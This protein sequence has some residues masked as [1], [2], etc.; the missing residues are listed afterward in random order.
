MEEKLR[1]YLKILL[2]KR[3]SD[4][5]LGTGSRA[6][7]RINGDMHIYDEEIVKNKDVEAIARAILTPLEYGKLVEDKE[8]DCSYDLDEKNRFRVNFFYQID[9]LSASMRLIPL[10]IRSLDDLRHPEVIKELADLD[11]GLVLVTGT[12]GSGKSTTMAA[13][14][15]RINRRRRKHIITIEDPIEFI[16]KDIECLVSQRAVGS[17]SRSYFTA[18]RAALREDI[19]IIFVGEMRDLETVEIALHAAN[20]GHLVFSTLHA[21][22]AKETVG[23]IIGMFPKEEKNRVRMDLSFVLEGVI[24]QRLVETLDGER[25]AA[26]EVMKKTKRVTELIAEERDDEILEAIEAGKKI[27]GSQSFDQ[28]LLGLYEEV[29]IDKDTVIKYATNPS[30]MKLKLE[31]VGGASDRGDSFKASKV[32]N[33]FV[34]KEDQEEKST[35]SKKY[36]RVVALP[37][38]YPKKIDIQKR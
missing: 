26:I 36:P 10:D 3:G 8:L 18:L 4:L 2:E 16:H 29:R 1:S 30:D 19:D 9:G 32:T 28:S 5:H 27:Y 31:G 6:Y 14:L 35:K 21:L 24:G 37:E 38:Y 12:S 33:N 34:L 15:D 17:S 11:R 13:I 20:T 25:T 22:D 23:R 7:M